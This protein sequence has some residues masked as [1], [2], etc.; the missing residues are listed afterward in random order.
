MGHAI[1]HCL[2]G[3]AIAAG[4][5][6]KSL[7]DPKQFLSELMLTP[8]ASGEST[9]V[10]QLR[11]IR[12]AMD[13]LKNR[14]LT[15]E[16]TANYFAVQRRDYQNILKGKIQATRTILE[17]HGLN[18]NRPAE[19][20]SEVLREYDSLAQKLLKTQG[21]SAC[22]ALCKFIDSQLRKD[23]RERCTHSLMLTIT[24]MEHVKKAMAKGPAEPVTDDTE[25]YKAAYKLDREL[26]LSKRYWSL[27]RE[28]FARAFDAMT[29]TLLLEQKR[30]N[31]FLQE[32]FGIGWPEGEDL[33][34][35]TAAIAEPLQ[36]IGVHLAPL[37]E[38]VCQLDQSPSMTRISAA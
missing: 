37:Q 14:E 27:P 17:N 6:Q 26:S 5:A 18:K 19:Q 22:A 23:D 31:P 12:K 20:Q 9:E 13:R 30:I 35:F 15:P 36:A 25:Y 1:D 34:A 8:E 3:R 32:S 2:G 21:S 28:M 29:Y 16:E 11:A 4:I 33:K 7:A 24:G 38:E 10:R